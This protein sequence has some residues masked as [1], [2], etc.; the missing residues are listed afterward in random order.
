[1]G[2]TRSAGALAGGPSIGERTVSE[3]EL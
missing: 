1:M 2:G 3:E